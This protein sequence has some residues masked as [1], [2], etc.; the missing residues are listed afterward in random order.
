MIICVTSSYIFCVLCCQWLVSLATSKSHNM[1]AFSK[2]Q[3]YR[4]E[5]LL[6]MISNFIGDIVV[7]LLVRIH[8]VATFACY[9]HN[10]I[11][12][13]CWRTCVH[14]SAEAKKNTHTTTAKLIRLRKLLLPLFNNDNEINEPLFGTQTTKVKLFLKK[15]TINKWMHCCANITRNSIQNFW[16]QK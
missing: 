2:S 16:E 11:W 13:N 15:Y 5:P 14:I 9:W 10:N 8:S 7:I 4:S 12:F 1:Y 6:R 3:S